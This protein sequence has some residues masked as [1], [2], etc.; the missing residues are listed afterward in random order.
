[1][2]WRNVQPVTGLPEVLARDFAD[3]GNAPGN[4]RII[5]VTT[6]RFCTASTAAIIT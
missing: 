4:G 2:T 6:L 1:M 3:G 5:Q